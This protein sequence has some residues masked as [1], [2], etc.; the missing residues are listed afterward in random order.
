MT[1]IKVIKRRYRIT[2]KFGLTYFNDKNNYCL[3]LKTLPISIIV[4]Q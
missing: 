1:K 3:F 4:L 2:E